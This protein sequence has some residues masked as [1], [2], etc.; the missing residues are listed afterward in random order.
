MPGGSS[1]SPD[2]QPLVDKS[3]GR[4]SE[5]KPGR[6]PSRGEPEPAQAAVPQASA[7]WLRVVWLAGGHF[8]S[9]GSLTV[10]NKWALGFYPQAAV[11]TLVQFVVTF[12][13][14]W[15]LG[16]LR[17]AEVDSLNWVKVKQYWPATCLFYITTIC[18]QMI[19]SR[20]GVELFVVI[21]CTAPLL[22][23]AGEYLF[24]N[25]ARPTAKSVLPLV[26][27]LLGAV[28]YVGSGADKLISNPSLQLWC[29]LYLVMM[30][31]DALCIKKIVTDVSFTPWG[32]VFYNNLLS[33]ALSLPMIVLLG[34][35]DGTMPSAG[36]GFPIFMTCCL[37]ISIS[38]FSLNVR[39][40]VTAAAFMVLGVMNKF[41]TL[42]LN[43]LFLHQSSGLVPTLGIVMVILGGVLWQVAMK[44]SVL[45]PAK[46]TLEESNVAQG[47]PAESIELLEEVKAPMAEEAV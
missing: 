7:D 31:I 12:V 17:L 8:V 13:V 4:R 24:L 41:L 45:T 21:R 18:S 22:T 16:A 32:L 20:G 34:E 6:R 23:F 2:E 30:P 25:G 9:A 33:A 1:L 43:A 27:L 19:L 47:E 5:R 35:A 26:M 40:T 14:A 15:T 38:F 29:G 36:A 11:L 39:K 3:S 10:A 28:V 44:E 37:A 42:T 46:S